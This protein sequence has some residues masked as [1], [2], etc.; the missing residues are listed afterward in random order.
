MTAPRNVRPGVTW[1]TTRRTTRRY[2]LLTPDEKGQ[3]EQ[4]YWYAT[5][6]TARDLGIELHM[7]QLMSTHPHEVLTDTRGVLPRFFELR[8]RLFANAIKVLL[9]WP[10]EVLS[11]EPANWVE[12]A[13]PEA[14]VKEMAYVAANC[15]AAGLVR[16]PRRWPGAKVL[17]EEVGRRVVKVKRPDF[18]FDPNNP[19][20][21]DEVTIPIVMPAMLTKTYGSEE[22]AREA[23]QAK[24]DELIR[25]AHA[26]NKRNGRGYAGRKRV[27]K[28][29]HTTR[30]RSYE[31]FGGRV[32]TFSAAGDGAVAANFVR[33]RREF[34]EDYRQA[35]NGWKAGAR[36]VVFP[37]G[38][39][40]MRLC[41]AARCLAPP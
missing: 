29:P 17:V 37:H 33:K 22:A 24:L 36:D 25:K 18:Y 28:T 40:K 19:K 4:A 10:E 30:A 27:L 32:P 35:W 31:E 5:A 20:W 34:L 1:F 2:H 16:T 39:W 15:V 13:T 8:N 14:M 9:G 41:H 26:D 6:V 7:M 12:L 23:I 11:K 38:T 21:P 3:V